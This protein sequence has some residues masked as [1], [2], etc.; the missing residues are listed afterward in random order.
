MTIKIS[1]SGSHS[2]GKTTLVGAIQTFLKLKGHTVNTVQEVA[3][4]SVRKG[5]PI[6]ENATY[7]TQLWIMHRQICRELEE[8]RELEKSLDRTNFLLCDRSIMDNC[9][10]THYLKLKKIITKEQMKSIIKL[11]KWW[12][13]TYK[14]I[15]FI[16]PIKRSRIKDDG[17]RSTDKKF[18]RRINTILLRYINKFQ[19]DF[20][21]PRFI[22]AN[23]THEKRMEIIKTELEESGWLDEKENQE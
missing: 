15:F 5:F 23:G 22:F 19:R 18:Q 3:R 16:E 21:E 12:I 2:T 17:V 11:M 9:A 1:I 7:E 14:L 8:S 6:N 10:Y 13:P 20:T 4:E